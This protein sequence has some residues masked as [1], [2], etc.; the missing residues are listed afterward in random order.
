MILIAP[1]LTVGSFIYY[2]SSRMIKRN[3]IAL[4][5]SVSPLFVLVLSLGRIL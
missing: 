3:S 2:F 5:L 4:L 1:L